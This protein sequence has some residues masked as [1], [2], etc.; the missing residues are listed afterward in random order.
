MSTETRTLVVHEPAK[1]DT[2]NLTRMVGV[3]ED[4]TGLA[5][6]TYEVTL[7]KRE[8]PVAWEQVGTIAAPPHW[9]RVEEGL[10]AYTALITGA[11]GV[12]RRVWVIKLGDTCAEKD[13]VPP[14]P[15]IV[16]AEGDHLI[17]DWF[18]TLDD[19]KAD[20]ETRWRGM[21]Q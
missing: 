1:I 4:C 19:A 2:F 18:C 6:G 14:E 9:G 12:E 10:D 8:G 16:A 13:G 5:P 21:E 11:D 20:A 3:L 17:S 15:W 7:T